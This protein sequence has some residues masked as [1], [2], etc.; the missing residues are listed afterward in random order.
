LSR[1]TITLFAPYL[2]N[3]VLPDQ[4]LGCG[5]YEQRGMICRLFAY[6][7]I[8]NK[9]GQRKIAACKPIVMAQPEQVIQ[10]NE[11]L[12]TKSNRAKSI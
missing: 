2:N 4:R 5:L 3:L 8:V 9:Y 6:N 11:L 7:Y 12:A 1:I 10:A